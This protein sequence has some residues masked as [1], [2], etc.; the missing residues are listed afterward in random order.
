[1]KHGLKLFLISI[2]F[3]SHHMGFA[4]HIVGGTLTYVHNGGSS[5]TVTLKLYRDC[6]GIDFP[7]T[8][9]VKITVLGNNGVP[10]PSKD[11]TMTSLSI[12]PVPSGLPACSTPPNPL[13]CTEEGTYTAVVNNFPPNA[14]GYHLYYQ[15]VARNYSLTNIN[16]TN[17]TNIGET[18]YAYIPGY[19][20]V[21][22]EDF[23][24][25]NGTTVDNGSTA[26]SS[27]A[28]APA[29]ATASV[30]NS[31]F[32]ITGA[33]NA[34]QTW[35]SQ[36]INI[37]AATS[38]VTASVNLYEAGTLE[39]T[40]SIQVYYRLNGGALTLFS[41]NGSKSDDFD[42]AAAS[43]SSL[44]GSTLQIVIKVRYSSTSPATEI[45]RF[46]D[47]LVNENDPIVNSNPT[48]TNFPPLFICKGEALSFDHSATDLDGDS[49]VYSFY[50]PYDGDNGSGPKDPTF[51]GNTAVFTPVVFLGGYS[52]TNPLGGSGLNI[53]ST[54]LLTGIPPALGQ[55]VVGVKVKE[56]RNGVYLDE[57]LRD[58]QFN[59]VTCSAPLA[60]GIISPNP[61]I[62]FGSTSTTISAD[63]SGGS[64]PYA[65]LWNN[66]NPSQSINVGV[67]TYTVKL[68]DSKNCAPVY[69]TATVTSFT[70]PVTS[71]AGSDQTICKTSP[72]TTLQGSVT[73]K[74]T[75][76]WSGGAGSFS[77][78][79]A[80]LSATYTPSAAE[81]ANGFVDLTLTTTNVG[82][83][84]IGTD[85]VRI[86][87][88]GFLGTLTV[89][90]TN[91]SCYGL[92]DGAAT[93]S[94]AGGSSPY[95]YFWTNSQ[96]TVTISNLSPTTYSVT[97]TDAIGCSKDTS[98]TI[99]EPDPLAASAVIT[100]V[101][102]FGGSNGSISITP[103]DGTS[104]YTYL[105]KPGNQTTSSISAQTQGSYTVTV[106]DFNG[107]TLQKVN[108][109][110]EPT[111]LSLSI[112]STDV[113]CFGG[114]DGT[115]NSTVSGGT[116]NYTY[117][118]TSGETAPDL[119]SLQE[120]SYSLTVTDAK[121]CTNTQPVVIAEPAVLSANSSTSDI[122]CNGLTDG[123]AT[124]LPSGGTA[125][126]TYVWQP[127]AQ[128]SSTIMNLSAGT[129]TVSVTDSKGCSAIAF[130]TVVEP[131]A[132]SVGFVSQTN[133][134]CF[135]GN[136]GAV[137]A[138]P[139]GGTPN[140][141]YSWLPGG[142]TTSTRSNLTSG[143][144]SVTVTDSK[145]CT[146]KN[147]VTITQPT[148]LTLS[149]SKTDETCSYS[150]DGTAIA[151]AAG[152]TS[153]YTY[154]W[155]PGALTSVSIS[156]LSNGTYSVT[157]TDSK[158]CTATATAIVNQPATLTVSFSGQTNVSCFAGSNG[159]VTANPSGG[160]A[161]YTYSWL[162]GGATT[163][164]VSNL[165]A[166]TYTVNVTDSKGCIVS[167]SV[168]ITQP[169][170]LSVNTS[171]TDETC[172]Y[173]DNG[174]ITS[175][176]TGGTSAYTYL[177]KPG[178]QVSSS[179]SGLTAGTYSLT[180]TDSKGCTTNSVAVVDEP[181]ALAINFTGQ[182][183]VSCF[184]GND[185]AVSTSI[186]GGTANYNYSWSPGAATTNAI[187]NVTA[188]TY[189]LTI[190][191]ANSCVVKNSVSITQ[192]VA[193]LAVS[194]SATDVT[195]YGEAD[196]AVSSSVTGG[197]AAYSYSWMPGSLTGQNISNL[198]AGT[199]SVTVTDGNGC[200][201]TNS[202]DVTQPS[203]M[204]LTTSSVNSD[205]GQPN[206]QTSV[207]VSGGSSPYF[208][209]WSPSGGSNATA[210]GLLAGTYSV[211][212]TDN[213]GCT[214]FKQENVS[215]NTA[216]IISIVS[217]T[218]V[219]CNGGNDGAATLGLTG[220]TG[221][222]TYSWSPSGGT[223]VTATGLVA[224]VYTANV[225]DANGC[226][227]SATTT[228]SISEPP[229][230]N[231]IVATAPVSCFGGNDGTASVSALGGTPGY[232]YEWL[233]SA[234]T[235]STISGLSATTYSVEVTDT[236]SCVQIQSFAISQPSAPLTVVVSST[237]VSCFGGTDGVVS[238][239]ASGGTAPYN[240]NWMPG[241]YNG[242]NVSNL[243][244]GT[245]TVT[246]EDS[247]LCTTTNTITVTEPTLI[248]LNTG[249]P[250]SYCSLPNGQANVTASGGVGG[251]LYQWSPTGGTN[252][253]ATGL[254]AGNYTVEVTD[255]NA[256]SAS[257]SVTVLDQPGPIASVS[258]TTNVTCFG[259]SDGT[260]TATFSGG[261]APFTYSWSASG[262]TNLAATGLIAGTYV[263]TVTDA[264]GCQSNSESPEIT[265]PTIISIV[266]NKTMVS[267]FGLSDG[268][269]SVSA[270]GSTPG[271]TY[272]W[273]PGGET[274]TSINNLSAGTYT[275]Q[276]TDQNNCVQS[277]PFEITEPDLL[278]T[279]I[280]PIKNVSCY[281]G[282]DG[283][284]TAAVSGGTQVYNYQ[285]LPIGGNGPIGTGFAANTYTVIVTDFNGCVSSASV[286]ITQPAI[287][288]S[289]S[290]VGSSTS[291][292]GGSDGTATIT[293]VGGTPNYSYLWNPSGQTAQNAS[294]L[295]AQTYFV[296]VTDNNGCQTNT[297]V[298][299]TEPLAI[300][301]TLIPVSPSCGLANGEISS[302]VSGGTSPYTYL[303]SSGSVTS[304]GINGVGPGTYTLQITDANNCSLSVSQTL[305]NIPGATVAVSSI[306]PVSCFG[307]ND[308]SATINIT[309]G[310]PPY[311]INWLPYGGNNL[312]AT[313]LTEATYTV[314]VTDSLGCL[315]SVSVPVLQ[316]TAISIS[317]ASITH[318]LCNGQSSASITVS[319]TG[320][321]PNYSYSWPVIG[322][323]AS[324]VNNI[325]A[326][327]YTVDVTDQ[328][329][330]LET[331]SINIT[332][333]AVLLSSIGNAVDPTCYGLKGIASV[334]V[335]GGTIPYNYS[336]STNP[337]LT[338]SNENLFAGSYTVTITDD[339]G[340]F[341]SSDVTLTEPS[342]VITTAGLDDTV[343]LGQSATLSATASGGAGNYY[344]AWQPTS[345]INAGTIML[346]P[347]SD[348]TYIVVGYDKIGCPGTPD[349]TTAYTYH[350]FPG[351]VDAVAISPICPGRNSVVSAIPLAT[352]G[353]LTYQWN[354]NLGS[355]PGEFIVTPSQP[356]T[357]VVTA[358][359]DVCGTSV[360][361]S[362]EITFNPQPSIAVSS[363]TSEL[364]VPGPI[365]FLDSSVTGNI[366]DPIISW[367]WNFGDGTF[368]TQ[369]N[370]VHIFNQEGTYFVTLTVGTSGG[371]TAV[372]ST[373]PL[374]IDA[375]RYPTAAFKVNSP[376]LTL[377]VDKLAPNNQ[378]VGA[379]SYVWSFGDG[380][381][382]TE[383][384][385]EYYY[386]SVGVFQIQLIA[387]SLYACS[388]TAYG[389]V[390]TTSDFIFPNV[391]T[392]SEDGP[393]GGG[394][395]KRGFSNNVFFPYTDGVIKFKIEIFNRWGELVFESNDINIGWDGYYNGQLCQQDVYIWKAFLKLNNGKEYNK[396]GDVTLLR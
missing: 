206:G 49:L 210:T 381:N 263:I 247:K 81:L 166:G 116:A 123:T 259:G 368:S 302:Q 29:P 146:A 178:L 15:L 287:S 379:N 77:P 9:A 244:M 231:I 219:S 193:A 285:W 391:F 214:S 226:K 199:Y 353:P 34:Q 25:A 71:N 56:Y 127:G 46:D 201:E 249:S 349:T 114:N 392:P 334:T 344:F 5:Y 352:T 128:T 75:G 371:C 70:V 20:L 192:P 28:G 248:T 126:Y 270:S 90:P 11:F 155:Q 264:N 19:P 205:C 82:S 33:N 197:T 104:P 278:T 182:I 31:M 47:I 172:D 304:S 12:V 191:D 157:T 343:C 169:T 80:T 105:W 328:N 174:S 233:P 195:C 308:G 357:Y 160:T 112:V 27:T 179:I 65:Y 218:N 367:N 202:I 115:A 113:S 135:G 363:D 124:A 111:A 98:V 108:T 300:S 212:V 317:I 164:S 132:L 348:T 351:D 99:T 329:N 224:G 232:T 165:I 289:A 297:S 280:S 10:I 109:I 279:I 64:P 119:T 290:G 298:A 288:L 324:S 373:S 327:T 318:V 377:P 156:A 143:T 101:S 362:V 347:T 168:S 225:V 262:G 118:W 365:Q 217:T 32:E 45:Y 208:Y 153:G 269:A 220:G 321:T 293:P 142:A 355:G 48:F 275:V 364:C 337:V 100:N 286:S 87:Y 234:T 333:P 282:N 354:N 319:A 161:G 170:L 131:S 181:T 198:I 374:T 299:V 187:T 171:P 284:A 107:C 86:N 385:P 121:G 72:T 250:D 228:P 393:T 376:E 79:S 69:A 216:P 310:S 140:Y 162:P 295:S 52:T 35:T 137:T 331:I 336:W 42:A 17:A 190:T 311:T 388:D 240:Y 243:P 180:V 229:P 258:S 227:A 260:A 296:V 313:T 133:V 43:Q 207:S 256:C 314:N 85:V 176:V 62:C 316:P 309:L 125:G 369:Q 147:T 57:T 306:T 159:A 60:I 22:A 382:S 150:N 340:C 320:G 154:L 315:S 241:N 93:V 273:L 129:Y 239:T 95:T 58:F 204:V 73:A 245:Y 283:E 173:S 221:P 102:C 1:M 222:F 345:V 23:T 267:C 236:K 120:G 39:S 274:G 163:A 144:Y 339:H 185:G 238:A 254:L 335:T 203:D 78:D 84:P 350:L 94:N 386:S 209:L 395:D 257:A 89:T 246:V 370:P 130:A 138:N 387:T 36:T 383:F 55:Y 37:S 356:T 26:W 7:I 53:S 342:Q 92:N 177:W 186:S 380:G 103:T 21:W 18:F 346:T 366:S 272:L 265:Q 330:C 175:S 322:S 361:D 360:V 2:F 223:G 74:S 122:T 396:S 326:G 41:T 96:T 276:V 384:N 149:T 325:G 110:S 312:T 148:Q 4:T 211:T 213:A 305:I 14:G 323:S 141:T 292:F 271:Y 291:C 281:Q 338:G 68:T 44:I 277:L 332:E 40:D 13:P 303:W 88:T 194:L 139:S 38:G 6:S 51:S 359:S 251:Y 30:N 76:V 83:C 183:N 230:I 307:G 235:G 196:G 189:S 237:P 184:G 394:Y 375:H 215:E 242:Q 117:S 390:S 252:A 61:V 54:G 266:V 255:A 167:N 16:S 294:G 50:T 106:T 8:S 261:T 63:P 200:T 253:T 59:V 378:S 389:E 301:A 136:N 158:G 3:C 24:L 268:A 341:T 97:I 372:N 67:G 151:F 188:G 152:G 66:T 134:S 358:T 145:G 91:V